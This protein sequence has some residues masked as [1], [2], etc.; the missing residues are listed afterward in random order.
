MAAQGFEGTGSRSDYNHSCDVA[1][2]PFV[3][4]CCQHRL[5]VCLMAARSII[6]R[7]I[8]AGIGGLND[9]N[10]NFRHPGSGS[11]STSDVNN[12]PSMG[13]LFGLAQYF[14]SHWRCIAFAECNVLQ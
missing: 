1:E 6:K 9:G 8:L 14:V 3:G 13:I 10:W 7:G 12:R 11:V 4:Q 2:K 5:I